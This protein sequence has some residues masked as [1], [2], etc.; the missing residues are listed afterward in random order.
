[1]VPKLIGLV[2]ELF[3]VKQGVITSIEAIFIAVPYNLRSP[4]TGLPWRR[5]GLTRNSSHWAVEQR[6]FP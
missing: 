2:F 3:K 5:G 4:W 1:M 6:S